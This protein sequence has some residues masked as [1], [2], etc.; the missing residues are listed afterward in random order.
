MCVMSGKR[1]M[2][3]G[4]NVMKQQKIDF[5]KK[6]DVCAGSAEA[7]AA[8]RR[9]LLR[10]QHGENALVPRLPNLASSREASP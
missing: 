3:A 4:T 5:K 10:Q 7:G 1:P 2:A 9:T 8:A 6:A